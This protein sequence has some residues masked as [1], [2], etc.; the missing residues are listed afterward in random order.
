MLGN[1]IVT[2]RKQLAKIKVTPKLLGRTAGESE[3]KMHRRLRQGA[4]T[5]EKLLQLVEDGKIRKTGDKG[6]QFNTQ[7]YE[8][9]EKELRKIQVLS[10]YL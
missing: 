10:S 2:D 6:T 4:N 3:E 9:P 7:E 5:L 8:T 1:H